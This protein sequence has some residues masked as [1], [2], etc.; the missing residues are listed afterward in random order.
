MISSN[1]RSPIGIHKDNI[2]L[3][4]AFFQNIIFYNSSGVF[5]YIQINDS[6]DL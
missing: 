6:I 3:S 2:V 5:D 1:F 4:R